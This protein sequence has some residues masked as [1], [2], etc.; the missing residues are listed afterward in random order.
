MSS[1]SR[2]TLA[3]LHALF[4]PRAPLFAPLPEEPDLEPP[5]NLDSVIEQ[6]TGLFE[7]VVLHRWFRGKDAKGVTHFFKFQRGLALAQWHDLLRRQRLVNV[8]G[9]YR[10]LDKAKTAP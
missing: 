5:L 10:A 9:P 1:N 3:A 6:D 7:G 4:E 8:A 2:A